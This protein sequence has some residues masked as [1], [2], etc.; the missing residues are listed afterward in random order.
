MEG[1]GLR[2]W[3][4]RKLL[5][6]TIYIYIP[7]YSPPSIRYVC[8]YSLSA[9][10]CFLPGPWSRRVSPEAGRIGE[11]LIAGL[12]RRKARGRRRRRSPKQQRLSALKFLEQRGAHHRVKCAQ[13][14]PY[15]IAENKVIGEHEHATSVAAQ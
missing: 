4:S 6:K 8:I 3:L 13:V 7:F 10:S 15:R 9:V 5:F 12:R 1:Q 11:A 2:G 14:E